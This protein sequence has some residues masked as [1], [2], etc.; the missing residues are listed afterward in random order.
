MMANN[1]IDNKSTI[2]AKNIQK[3]LSAYNNNN[4][5]CATTVNNQQQ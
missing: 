4:S 2:K 3:L 5:N 1:N